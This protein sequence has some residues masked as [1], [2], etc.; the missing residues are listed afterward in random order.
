MVPG[1]FLLFLLF[2]LHNTSIYCSNLKFSN[3]KLF[4]SVFIFLIF[5]PLLILVG[6]LSNHFIPLAIKQDIVLQFPEYSLIN[7]FISG[8]S[9]IFLAPIIE[10]FYF[11]KTLYNILRD[12]FNVFTSIII[13]SL[14]FGV[15]HQNVYAFPTLFT[16]GIILSI[17]FLIT[18]SWIYCSFCHS[19][20]NILMIAQ[21][22]L[23]NE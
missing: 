16:L 19:F 14:Y 22:I 20:F 13:C 5:F 3:S 21:I 7:K 15:V 17:I 23:N 4:K 6:F 10:E 9:I 1:G 18:R 8:I 11:R 12:N 2:F